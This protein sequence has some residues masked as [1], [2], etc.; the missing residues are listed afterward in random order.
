MIISASYKTDIPA[1]YGSWFAER[2]AA[3]GCWVKNPWNGRR[4]FVDLTADKVDGF[5]FWTKNLRPFMTPLAHS[6]PLAMAAARA[7]FMV[8]LTITG[9]PRALE[10]SVVAAEQAIADVVTVNATYGRGRVVWRYDPIIITSITAAD[11]HRACFTDLAKALEGHVD[12]VVVSF[13]QIYAKTRRNLNRALKDGGVTWRDP[14]NEE[15]Q[16]LL[17]DLA[18]I[19]QAHGMILTTCA[20]PELLANGARAAKCIDA[21]RLSTIGGRPIAAR[22][23][24]NRPGCACAESRDIG[25]YDTCPHGCAYCY[26]VANPATAKARYQGHEPGAEQL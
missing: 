14:S 3:G 8:Q 24:P 6:A 17:G 16:A 5:V 13:V 1:F 12:E 4:F 11:W 21:V 20:Q 19:A 15:K 18:A 7:P 25:G 23:K 26:A 22:E 9:Y 2:L 10:T